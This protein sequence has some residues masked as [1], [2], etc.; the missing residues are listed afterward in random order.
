MN[1]WRGAPLVGVKTTVT[2]LPA[3]AAAIP[4]ES[5]S[6]GRKRSSTESPGD[7]NGRLVAPR[8]ELKVLAVC[9]I[10]LHAAR[11]AEGIHDDATRNRGTSIRNRPTRL[12][13]IEPPF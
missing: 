8:V 1:A 11:V 9:G 2:T 6:H 3:G 10:R 7:A 5:L 12:A 13:I 4:G